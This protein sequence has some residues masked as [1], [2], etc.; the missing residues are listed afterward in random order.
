MERLVKKD[1]TDMYKL[2]WRIH[3]TFTRGGIF[4]MY[5]SHRTSIKRYKRFV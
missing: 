4:K 3:A 5:G 2:N 1:S